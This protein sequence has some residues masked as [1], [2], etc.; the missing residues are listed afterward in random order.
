MILNIM[1]TI[2]MIMVTS[3]KVLEDM[4]KPRN[5]ILSKRKE[6]PVN[7]I[8]GS[9]PNNRL[10]EM[11]GKI[12]CNN[13]SFKR[14]PTDSLIFKGVILRHQSIRLQNIPGDPCTLYNENI[15]LRFTGF[16]FSELSAF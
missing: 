4:V 6:A 16:S 8:L 14:F 5:A 12:K 2:I 9:W 3:C 13:T 1:I 7:S 11:Q 10:L 15:A